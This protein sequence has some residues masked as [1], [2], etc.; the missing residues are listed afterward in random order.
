[1]LSLKEGGEPVP[2]CEEFI[3]IRKNR[4]NDGEDALDILIQAYKEHEREL[5]RS[6]GG[7]NPYLYKLKARKTE[8][9][10]Q[11]YAVRMPIT[12]A[13]LLYLWDRVKGMVAKR[14]S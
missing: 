4:A 5:L 14:S 13:L 10:V 12:L 3:E 6:R 8:K 1:M 11:F 9:G 7:V 2:D